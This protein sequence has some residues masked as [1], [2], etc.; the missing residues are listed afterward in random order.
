[1]TVTHV[2]YL[3]LIAYARQQVTRPEQ[4]TLARY[5]SAHQ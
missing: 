1:M 5:F 4:V 3:G 2:Q